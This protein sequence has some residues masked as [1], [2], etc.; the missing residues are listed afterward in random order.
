MIINK[1]N[2]EDPALVS[3]L[4]ELPLWSAPFGMKLLDLIKLKRE[5][6]VLDIGSGTG[7]PMLEIAQRLD[8]ASHIYGIDPWNSATNRIR[9]KIEIYNISNATI[10]DC[11]AEHLPFKDEFFDLIISNNGL[12]NVENI[13]EALSE[14]FRTAKNGGQLIFTMNMEDTMFEFYSVY[15]EVLRSLEMFQEVGK[16][17][18]HIYQKRKPIHEVESFVK[19][20]GFRIENIY[21]DSFKYRFIDGTSMFNHFAIGL[22]FLPSWLNILNSNCVDTVFSEIE[23]KLNNLADINGELSLTIPFAVFDCYK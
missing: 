14:C 15:E 1:F 2:P 18:N 17:K 16:M 10:L 4:D 21:Y 6:N 20:A 9:E 8:S 12:N 3:V 5:V 13:N 11:K 19:Q 22:A 7:F 23:S